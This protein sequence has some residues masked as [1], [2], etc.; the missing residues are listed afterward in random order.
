[1]TDMRFYAVI[2]LLLVSLA[3]C[4]DGP[5]SDVSNVGRF[6]IE[7]FDS[8]PPVDLDSI[9]L[10]IEEISVHSTSDGWVTISEPD[11]MVDFLGLINGV[12]AVL[13]DGVLPVGHYTQMRFILSDTNQI[14]I[15]G[16]SYPLF[17]PS[18]S[19]SGVKL[20]LGF[21]IVEDEMIE[22]LIDFDAGKSIVWN[23][24]KYIL[25]PSFK[26]FKKVISVRLSGS[27]A[28]T[29]GQPIS[30]ALIEATGSEYSSSTVSDE[31]GSYML[32]LPQG[33]YSIGASA[34]GYSD[35]D[36]TYTGV[37]VDPDIATEYTG[38]DF[39]LW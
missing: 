4:S 3:G 26:A 38:Y 5:T 19:Q 23:P 35:V 12:T 27:V 37:T 6:S 22:I 25:N 11:T 32:I 30:N 31:F 2:I 7:V 10:T 34:V 14:T 39:T 17:V 36:T 13:F 28:N 29:L 24:Q 16:E 18:G 15:D 20:H 1:M 33:T 8:P 21:D 9:N